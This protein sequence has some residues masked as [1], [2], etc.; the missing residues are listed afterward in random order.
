MK[1]S[2]IEEKSKLTCKK[3]FANIM[4]I[5][6]HSAKITWD[7][8]VSVMYLLS[9]IFDPYIFAFKFLP[10]VNNNVNNLEIVIT[11]SLVIDIIL[12]FFTAVK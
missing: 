10:L 8:Y 4:I 6:E 12:K 5:P 7:I 11:F 2:E 3:A 9:Y 1:K